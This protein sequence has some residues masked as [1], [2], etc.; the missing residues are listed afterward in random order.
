MLQTTAN[1][2]KV[3][4][5]KQNAYQWTVRQSTAAE[6]VQKLTALR[7]AIVA[8]SQHRPSHQHCGWTSRY[9]ASAAHHRW[10]WPT[11]PSPAAAASQRY[12]GQSTWWQYRSHASALGRIGYHSPR[13]ANRCP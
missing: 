10:Q 12:S 1:E 4:F 8:N 9:K 2:M 7:D 6:R 5:D 11:W 13:P 3:I